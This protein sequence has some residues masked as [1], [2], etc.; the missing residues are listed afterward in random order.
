MAQALQDVVQALLVAL[1]VAGSVVYVAWTLASRN[2]RAA[3]LDFLLRAP[4]PGWLRRW[5]RG[6]QP[7]QGGTASSGGCH[8]ESCP[9]RCGG[10]PEPS[11]TV[12][13]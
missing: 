1:L 7:A 2:W 10:V 11:C 13:K 4:M 3:T 5:L 9:Q 8:C 12:K 6:R